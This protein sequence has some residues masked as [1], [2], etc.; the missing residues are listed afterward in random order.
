MAQLIHRAQGELC[1][2][3]ALFGGFAKPF[4]S[5]F[6]PMLGLGPQTVEALTW[7]GVGK[8]LGTKAKSNDHD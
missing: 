6:I 8:D 4:H 1:N 7:Q 3:I 5:P 2:R